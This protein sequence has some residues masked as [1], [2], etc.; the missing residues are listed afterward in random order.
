MTASTYRIS[1]GISTPRVVTEGETFDIIYK[2][3]NIGNTTFPGGR[4]AVELSWSSL[5]EKV[6][7]VIKI[8]EQLPPNGETKP[9]SHNQ[10]PLTPGYTWFYVADA[11]ASDGKPVEVYK[12]SE[13]PLWP[14]RQISLGEMSVQFRQPLHAVRA[15]TH[16][17]ISQQRAL[18]VAAGSLALLVVIQIIDWLIRYYF[19]T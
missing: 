5:N 8:G 6:Y 9:I 17:E 7:Q 13:T 4:I 16:E 2:V 3:K 19:K 15:R 12:N 18:W 14:H 10:A 1:L 11:S